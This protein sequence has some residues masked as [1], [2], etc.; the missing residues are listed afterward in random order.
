MAP[1]LIVYSTPLCPPCE[2]LKRILATEGLAF[3]VVDLLVDAEAAALMEREGIRSSPALSI[4]GRIYAGADLEMDNL[5]AL[6]D[7]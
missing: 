1:K 2:A 5:V 7:L 4:D 3:D 6:L